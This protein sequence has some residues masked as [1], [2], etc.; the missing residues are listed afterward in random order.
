MISTLFSKPKQN[1]ED[2]QFR[3]RILAEIEEIVLSRSMF[4]A[5][6]KDIKMSSAPGPDGVP[7]YLSSGRAI[8]NKVHVA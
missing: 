4:V 6:M 2:I 7:A 8:G 3:R 1:Y 5:A